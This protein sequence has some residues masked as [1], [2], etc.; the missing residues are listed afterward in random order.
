MAETAPPRLAVGAVVVEDDRLLMVRRGRGAAAGEWSVPGGR[1]EWGE[2]MAEALVRE[3]H[4]ET[5]V[6]VV[7]E[8]L[9]GW[10]ERI[11]D[12]HHFVIFD[13]CARALDVV[14]PTA[15]DDAVEA[16][17]VPLHQVPELNLVRG[18]GEFLAAH[19]VIQAYAADG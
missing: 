18:L 19:K 1:L 4:E 16:A 9:L 10:V 11:D 3:V 17:W 6:E 15:G 2:T 7:C 8:E 13:F 14:E 5:G 12:E